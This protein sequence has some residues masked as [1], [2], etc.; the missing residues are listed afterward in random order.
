MDVLTEYCRNAL[1]RSIC[2]QY[3]DDRDRLWCV[4]LDPAL[5]ELINGHLER[6]ERGTTNTMPPQTS[7][8]I[9]QQI[10]AKMNELTQTGRSAV[11]LCSP[12]IR[13]PLRRMIESALPQT[14]V[15]AYNEVVSEVSVEAVAMVG[16]NG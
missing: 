5:E 4:T 9:V 14:A 3:V 7:Q 16:L 11:L 6:N 2:K 15:L 8:Q 13:L 1:S 10:S 12:Q